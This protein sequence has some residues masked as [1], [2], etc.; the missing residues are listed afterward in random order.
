MHEGNVVTEAVYS[1][2][3]LVDV[4]WNTP[5]TDHPYGWKTYSV[6]PN[7]SQHRFVGID[8]ESNKF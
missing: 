3:F 5:M 8:F 4:L 7:G 2:K 1:D 6:E